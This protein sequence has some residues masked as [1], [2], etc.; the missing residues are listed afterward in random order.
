MEEDTVHLFPITHQYIKQRESQQC[1]YPA[2]AD[3]SAGKKPHYLLQACP[4]YL[5][6]SYLLTPP[7]RI[8]RDGGINP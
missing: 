1:R 8:E 2:Y 7:L 5:A 6:D 4:I 3:I